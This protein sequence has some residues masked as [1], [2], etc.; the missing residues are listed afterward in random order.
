M[1]YFSLMIS[2][3]SMLIYLFSGIMTTDS[4]AF[5][6]VPFQILEVAP[7]IYMVEMRKFEGDTLEFHK[8]S[9][10]HK[11]LCICKKLILQVESLIFKSKSILLIKLYLFAVLQKYIYWAER[12]RLESRSDRWRNRQWLVF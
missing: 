6:C 10:I 12:Y 1:K 5:L 4:N 2:P 7:S 9:S 8:V 3:Q 11:S